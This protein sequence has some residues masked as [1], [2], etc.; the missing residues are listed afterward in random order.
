MN[1]TLFGDGGLCRCE[2]VG[3]YLIRV[4]L[5]STRTGVLMRRESGGSAGGSVVKKSPPVNA[6][7]TSSSPNPG[8]P[9]VPLR[10]SARVPLLERAHRNK[11]TQHS[12]VNKQTNRQSL[13]ESGE[14]QGGECL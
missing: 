8:G 3:S 14:T 12:Q 2:Q 4:G 1:V 5:Q 10:D 7:A 9:H 11:T 6:G 13:D